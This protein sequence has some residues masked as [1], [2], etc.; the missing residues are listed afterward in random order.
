MA[1]K[2][3]RIQTFITVIEVNG[4]SSAATRLGISTAAVSKQIRELEEDLKV[5][6]IERTTRR[7]HLTEA[8]QGYYDQC[9]RLMEEVRETEGIATHLTAEPAGLLSVFVA[10]HFG[11]Q[12]IVPQL[13]AFM[14]RYP[15]IRINLDLGERI[16]D[17]T[18]ET[19]DLIVGVTLAGPDLWIQKKIGETRYV[20]C[21]SSEYLTEYGVPKNPID[22]VQHHYIQH[23]M[24]KNEL[25]FNSGETLKIVPALTLNDTRSMLESALSGLGIV[26]LHEY[27]VR[28]SLG[29]GTLVEVLHRSIKPKLPIYIFYPPRRFL[30]SK[31]RV[32]MEYFAPMF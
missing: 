23:K 22:L 28:A 15:K 3:E 19:V 8:G 12:I 13:K 5:Q 32:F 16:P 27:V 20:F 24:R 21:A 2:L 6:L 25:E 7:L 10:R 18:L 26:L 17:P 11:E 1:L 31:V 9:K 4:F 30:P 29:R 14:S